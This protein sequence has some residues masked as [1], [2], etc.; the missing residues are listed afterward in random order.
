MAMA[1]KTSDRQAVKAP[2]ERQLAV[3]SGKAAGDELD[4]F[5]RQCTGEP[6]PLAPVLVE[7]E[8][9]QKEA[10]GYS[11]FPI[12]KSASWTPA[13]H[14]ELSLNSRLVQAVELVDNDQTNEEAA[15]EAE[16]RKMKSDLAGQLFVGLENA[17]ASG[18]LENVFR[19]IAAEDGC[20][21]YDV[22]RSATLDQAA[23]AERK[24][25]KSEMGGKLFGGLE[26]AL[27]SG[28]L[29]VA[30]L[31]VAAEQ[32]AEAADER[33]AVKTD[34]S[35]KLFSGLE[36][37][38]DNGALEDVFHQIAKEEAR[39]A[40]KAKCAGTFSYGLERALDDGSLQ[41]S[42]QEAAE[43]EEA[44]GRRALKSEFS[45]SLFSG[46]ETALDSGA[47]EGAFREMEEE[48]QHGLAANHPFGVPELLE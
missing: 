36:R 8:E 27:E 15:A 40:V 6:D 12:S 34:M 44:A 18:A 28:A 1:Q 9:E 39:A 23:A 45:S 30:F 26:R 17:L 5:S 3:I 38:V 11:H 41:A 21:G 24:A 4:D 42:S 13:K 25:L 16:R 33:W 10:S 37:A 20:P 14:V 43:A 7:F 35:G 2:A 32:E 48:H 46:L 29:E 31:E 19:E 47:L 22:L